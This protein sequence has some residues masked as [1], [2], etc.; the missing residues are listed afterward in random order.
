[1][2]SYNEPYYTGLLINQ[3]IFIV[4]CN[5]IKTVSVVSIEIYIYMIIFKFMLHIIFTLSQ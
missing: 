2:K 3:C 1:M 5:V 4:L